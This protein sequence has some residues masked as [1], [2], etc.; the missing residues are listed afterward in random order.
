[1]VQLTA[2]EVTTREV[3]EWR[4]LVPSFAQSRTTSTT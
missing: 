4:G 1:M 2:A 3:L